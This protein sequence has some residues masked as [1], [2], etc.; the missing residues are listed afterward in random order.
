MEFGVI[1]W[2]KEE[3]EGG[4]EEFDNFPLLFWKNPLNKSS[5]VFFKIKK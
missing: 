1:F 2:W 4:G 5:E 3:E